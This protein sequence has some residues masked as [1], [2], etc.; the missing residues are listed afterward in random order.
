MLEAQ[1]WKDLGASWPLVLFFV[2]AL[3]FAASTRAVVWLTHRHDRADARHHILRLAHETVQV[4]D[5]VERDLASL[6]GDVSFYEYSTRCRHCRSRA[7]AALAHRDWLAFLSE[8]RLKAALHSLHQ[9]HHEAVELRSEVDAK[10]ALWRHSGSA[11]TNPQP[12]HGAS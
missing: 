2:V 6:S 12:A 1:L 11:H 4:I 3:F 10:L 9:D 7:D 8:P 5:S